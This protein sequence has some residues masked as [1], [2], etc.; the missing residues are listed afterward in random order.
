MIYSNL[1]RTLFKINENKYNFNII[2]YF[3]VRISYIC[4]MKLNKIKIRLAE[5][6]VRQKDLEE[7]IG[8]NSSTVSY[9]VNN[10]VQ[11][12]LHVLYKIA[13][14]L[15][16]EPKDLLMSLEEYRKQLDEDILIEN[17]DK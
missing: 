15:N 9:W 3:L 5:K 2:M 17:L 8:R 4:I 6:D 10:K 13:D 1:I 12:H 14:H 7:L 11:P 16:I